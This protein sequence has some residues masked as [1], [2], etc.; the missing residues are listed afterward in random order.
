MAIYVKSDGS[1]RAIPIIPLTVQS[2]S[3]WLAEQD[4]KTKT[5]LAALQFVAKPEQILLLPAAEGKLQ[6]V[7]IGVDPANS[8]WSL[9]ALPNQLPDGEYQLQDSAQL[10]N[11]NQAA[12]GW[13]LGYYQFDRYKKS[14]RNHFPVLLLPEAVLKQVKLYQ[15]SVVWIR[16]LINT[17][18]ED[19]GPRQLAREVQQLA[20]EFNAEYHEIIG[21]DLLQANYPAIHTVGRAS[22]E[23][24]RL[25]DIRWGKADAPKITL[26]GKG[27]C[28]DSGGLDI[29]P[30]SAMAIMKKDM[31]GAAQALG[32]A[33]L[34]MAH[35]LP[36][37]LRVMIPAVENAI[38]NNAFRP[39]DIIRTRKGLSVEVGNTDAEG[40][41]ILS[42]ALSEAASE[43]PD[44]IVDFATLTGAARVALGGELPALFGN[45]E[46]IIDALKVHCQAEADLLWHMPLY[47]PYHRF[48]E[49]KLADLTNDS[50]T[51]LGGSITAALFLK[52]FVGDTPWLHIDLSAWN[53]GSRP[54]RPE[55]GEA[56]GVRALFAYLK[57]RYGN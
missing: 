14:N 23:A 41:L 9:A 48:I 35:D 45:D 42:D 49:A 46:T 53:Y 39:G 19:M 1:S 20:E 4:T 44:L 57:Q 31:G 32:L 27:V 28:F 18:A 21:S 13:C 54:G 25:C 6:Q 43:T 36:I 11:L 33:R 37:R 10:L 26:V 15:Q 29:K 30:A 2:F 8:L 22:S 38:S 5:W 17:P 34:I 51:G 52:D 7:L 24:P 12:L 16:D 40:R 50:S 47:Q 56:M 55:G 3:A